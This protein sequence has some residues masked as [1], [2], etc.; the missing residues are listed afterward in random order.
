[1][2]NFIGKEITTTDLDEM[3]ERC[4]SDKEKSMLILLF[5]TASRPAELLLIRKRNIKIYDDKIVLELI[6]LK[7]G[8]GRVQS[9]DRNR[10]FEII[11]KY[12]KSLPEENSRVFN[13]KQTYQIRQMVYRVSDNKYCPYFF[14]HN[15]MTE[16]AKSGAS[17]FE[18]QAFKGAKQLSSISPYIHFSGKT[19]ERLK[20]LMPK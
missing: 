9:F 14:R 12:S 20:D 1:M 6:S 10:Y 13:Y 4:R 3:L 5:Y 11:V 8:V 17:P 16:L 7:G 2:Q 15:R 18:L 19:L